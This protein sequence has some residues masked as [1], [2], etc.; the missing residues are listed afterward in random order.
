VATSRT[1]QLDA[2][3]SKL[4][5]CNPV[6]G[7]WVGSAPCNGYHLSVADSPYAAQQKLAA[8][9]QQ[10]AQL[11]RTVSSDEAQ[12]LQLTRTA[13]GECAG[14]AG[15][16]MSGEV[17]QGPRC[18]ADWAAV[19]AYDKQ[20]GLAVKQ[21]QLSALQES[22]AG[23]IS[24]TGSAQQ[25]Y[26]A[27][28]HGAI[29]EAV[30][31]KHKDLDTQI[32]IIDEWSALEQLSNRSSFVFFGHWLLVLVLIA[33]DCLP[34]LAKLMGGSSAYDQLLSEE[35]AADERVHALDVRFR[36]EERSVDKEI[37][38]YAAKAKK[39]SRMR[40]IDREERVKNAQGIND[41]FDEVRTLAAR[42]IEEGKKG[43]T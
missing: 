34:V 18:A 13:Q 19:S 22:I 24:Q 32:G 42:W 2:Y 40:E 30:G 7:L 23:M 36:E 16:D 21:K 41:G 39:R 11:K 8:A 9:R 12:E 38:I 37:G 6:S 25:V 28:L 26:A 17:G 4:Q 1:A 27:K 5:T 33:L 10:Q 43:G 31:E 15:T 29:T 35:R 14:R 20:S 3:E